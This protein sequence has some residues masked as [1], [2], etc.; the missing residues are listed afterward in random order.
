MHHGILCYMLTGT[1]V[2]QWFKMVEVCVQVA[3]RLLS[4]TMGWNR[5]SKTG[6]SIRSLPACVSSNEVVQELR[7]LLFCLALVCS[8]F[9]LPTLVLC[10]LE[11]F[12]AVVG[13]EG[14]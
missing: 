6:S 4:P 5:S 12:L 1:H 13:I 10:G 3:L 9:L 14:Q 11:V 7:S 2:S 8:I